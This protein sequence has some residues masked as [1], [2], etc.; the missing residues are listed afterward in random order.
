[1]PNHITNKITFRGN[2]TNI[3]TILTLI[4]GNEQYIDFE[5]ILPMPSNIYQGNLGSAERERYGSNN[6]YDWSIAHWGTKWN[7]YSSDFN[8]NEN[9][10]FFDT[11]WSAP[12]PIFQKLAEICYEHQVDF[13]GAW[14]DE[15]RGYNIGTFD[16]SEGVLYYD[17]VEECSNEAYD[18]YVELK[19]E[20]ECMGKDENGNWVVY[21]CDN[22][23][24][25][26]F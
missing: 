17:Y 20:E 12:I 6:W 24:R 3:N 19:G 2:Q 25:K 9:T 13:E 26:C 5:R 23:P 15:N 10:I 1:M 18:I 8:G 22:C 4:R 7:A 11:A 14:A 21:D 16:T